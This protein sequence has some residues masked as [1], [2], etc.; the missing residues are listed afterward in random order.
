MYDVSKGTCIWTFDESITLGFGFVTFSP[1]GQL[2]ACG[3]EGH[4]VQI[5]DPVTGRTGPTLRGH[6]KR[7]FQVAFRPN[8]HQICMTAHV[9]DVAFI[10]VFFVVSAF[11]LLLFLTIYL[12][13]LGTVSQ[14]RLIC[15]WNPTT[16]DLDAV[17]KGHTSDIQSVRFSSDGNLLTSYDLDGV[18]C[19][20]DTHTMK[21]V[22]SQDQ[23]YYQLPASVF[24]LPGE[25]QHLVYH[26]EVATRLG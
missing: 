13:K 26:Y 15:L 3:I 4:I 7:I 1:D 24:V 20:W 2:A 19:I 16:G 21:T 12:F 18:V 10:F 14:D 6:S 23:L 5:F 9:V 22:N 8:S 17:F 25:G 11:F